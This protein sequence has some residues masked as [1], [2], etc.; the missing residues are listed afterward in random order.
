MAA[1]VVSVV[2]P[3]YNQ[4]RYLQEAL[5]SVFRQTFPA[6]EIIVVNDGSSDEWTEPFLN[7][8]DDSRVTVI[9]RENGGVSAARN[10][11]IAA[12]RG[13]YIFALDADDLIAPVFLEKAVAVLDADAEVGLVSCQVRRFGVKEGPWPLPPVTTENM[14]YKKCIVSSCAVF[15]K[16]DWAACGGFD[17]RLTIEEDYDFWL[18]VI[19]QGRRL[20]R[21]EEC[22]FFYRVHKESV[23]QRFGKMPKL[24]RVKRTYAINEY[25]FKKHIRL[26]CAHPEYMAHR[27]F[28]YV[29]KPFKAAGLKRVKYRLLLALY[30]AL[31][32]FGPGEAA[33]ARI[34]RKLDTLEVYGKYAHNYTML[35][36]KEG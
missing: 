30:G 18:S 4:G 26:Y 7:S 3:C 19:E 12:A 8:L 31:G 10:T 24:E 14:L 22:L 20:H 35:N 17:I 2:I 29:V 5:D 21:M 33:R 25:I 32:R 1:P 36:V 13:K 16:E 27:L 9:H 28:P 34:R 15:R 11:G 23:I 6:L